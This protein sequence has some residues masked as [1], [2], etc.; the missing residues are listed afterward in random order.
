M[1]NPETTRLLALAYDVLPVMRILN[2]PA[3]ELRS[4]VLTVA[5]LIA[6]HDELGHVDAEGRTALEGLRASAA[7]EEMSREDLLA[8][9]GGIAQALSDRVH[10]LATSVPPQPLQAKPGGPADA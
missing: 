4:D 7:L 2:R 5:A 6:M 1:Y 3:S 10:V 9:A 8:A